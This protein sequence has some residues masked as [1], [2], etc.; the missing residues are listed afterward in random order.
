FHF[1]LGLQEYTPTLDINSTGDQTIRVRD[2]G[3]LHPKCHVFTK[4]L[5]LELRE[6]RVRRGGKIVRASGNG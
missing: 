6:L 1:L 4:S 3:T 5:L 2:F